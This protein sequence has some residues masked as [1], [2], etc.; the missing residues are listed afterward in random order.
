MDYEEIA[1]EVR[2]IGDDESLLDEQRLGARA[3][4]LCC[5]ST[6]QE[7]IRLRRRWQ[8]LTPLQREV[9]TL[10]A[11]L[12]SVNE[13]LFQRLRRDIRSGAL[14]GERLRTYLDRFTAYRPQATAQ[15]HLGY[16]DLD[17][18]VNGLFGLDVP[19]VPT[20]R[21][22]PEMIHLEFT[23]ARAILD[24]VDHAGIQATDV[25]CDIGS[26]L[27]Q[28]T[29]LVHLLTGIRAIGI[30][31]EP[32][33]CH[34]ARQRAEELGLGEVAF[35]NADARHA[36]YRQATLLFMFSPFRG[37]MLQAVLAKLRDQARERPFRLCTYGPCTLQVAK[38]PWLSCINAG[39]DD[40]YKLAIFKSI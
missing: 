6:A 18:L 2:R 25:F 5:L 27:G 11:R 32:A 24:L 39:A 15:T 38:Q 4:A 3:Q 37:F 10:R 22:E 20:R 35:V 13:R 1:R 34:F 33:Y 30:E 9:E 8:D 16:D 40:A 26:G 23:P 17:L 29:I 21:L 19:P 12:E 28:V 14:R 36:D 7:Y 31:A